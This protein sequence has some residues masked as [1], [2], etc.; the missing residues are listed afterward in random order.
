[1]PGRSRVYVGQSVPVT[2]ANGGGSLGLGL[3]LSRSAQVT[4]A[5]VVVFDAALALLLLG[6]RDVEVAV[7][8][9]AERRRPGKRPAHAPLVGLQLL[10]RRSRHRRAASR[11]GWP[12]ATA[13]AVEAVGNRRARRT[14]GLVVG[15]EH[16]VIDEELRAPSEEIRQRD[17]ALVGVESILL[18][19][20]APTAAPVAARASSSLRRVSSFSASSKSSRCCQPFS[21]ASRCL[22]DVHSHVCSFGMFA[23][24]R[25]VCAAAD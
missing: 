3:R 14:A 18:V 22:C 6:E 1:M 4:V 24:S 20:P 17:A 7:E 8:V 12:D 21:R 9:A 5:P 10:E 2:A 15:A 25:R 13:N 16:E 11:R 19:D 23:P